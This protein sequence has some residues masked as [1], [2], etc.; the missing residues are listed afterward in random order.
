MPNGRLRGI[1]ADLHHISDTVM[2]L[3]AIAPLCEGPTTIRNVAN[4]RIKETDR[5]LATVTELRRL[6]QQVEQFTLRVAQAWVFGERASAGCDDLGYRWLAEQA[7]QQ[8]AAAQP[9][10]ASQQDTLGGGLHEGGS[11]SPMPSVWHVRRDCGYGRAPAW[12][13]PSRTVG[14]RSTR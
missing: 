12:G 14:F 13:C 1:D 3:A 10:G 6:G 4:I 5:L 2:T 7:I 11:A 8:V 9:S